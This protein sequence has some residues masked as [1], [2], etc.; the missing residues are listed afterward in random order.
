[1]RNSADPFSSETGIIFFFSQVCGNGFKEQT[2]NEETSTQKKNSIKNILL[3]NFF[4]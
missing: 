2:A 1:M 3:K 4:L